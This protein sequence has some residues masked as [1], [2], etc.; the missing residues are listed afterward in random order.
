MGAPTILTPHTPR[1]FLDIHAS[2]G[3]RTYA[4]P[5]DD[6]TLAKN[7]FDQIWRFAQSHVDVAHPH[8]VML[9]ETAPVENYGCSEFP[10]QYADNWINGNGSNSGYVSSALFQNDSQY[11]VLRP[12]LSTASQNGRCTL[13]PNVLSPPYKTQ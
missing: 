11:V 6:A 7:Y 1:S 13:F 12:W 2:F 4:N 10:Y 3:A 9:G 8:K 5:A